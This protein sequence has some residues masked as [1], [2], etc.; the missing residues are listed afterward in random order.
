M[1]SQGGAPGTGDEVSLVKQALA[2]LRGLQGELDELRWR[3]NE[4]VAI[5]GVGCR[6]PG[7]ND[8]EELWQLLLS[9]KDAISEVPKDRWDI[10]SLY[11]RDASRPG[12]VPSRRGGFLP[13]L[14]GMDAA[15]FG[16]SPREAPHVDP[17]QRVMLEIAWEALEDAGIPPDSLARSRTGVFVA[18]LTNDYDHLLFNDLRRAEIYSG[19]GTANSVVA[20]RL[21]YF[22]NL[23]G[24]SVALDTACSGS[25]VAVHL[26]CASLRNGESSLALAG[27]VSVN[28][29]A[30]SNVFFARSGALSPAGLCRTFDAAADG[31]VRSDG[32]AVVVLKRLS[33]ALRDGNAIQA[34]VRGSAVNHD[35]HSNGIMAPNGEAQRAVLQEAY[36]RAGVSPSA[37]QFIELHGTGTPLG[38]PIE[39]QA[40]IDVLGAGRCTPCVVG[41]LKSNVGHSEAAAGAGG[42]VKTVLAMRHG[43]IP[44][45]AN[46]HTLNPLIPFAGTAFHV[47]QKVEPW[48]ACSSGEAAKVPYLAGVSGFGF[49]GTNAHVVLEQAPVPAASAVVSDRPAFLLPVSAATPSA[50]A[51][52]ATRTAGHLLSS[53]D[54]TDAICRSAALGRTHFSSRFAA[55]G[56]T[57]EDLAAALG[58]VSEVTPGG[59][60]KLAFVFSGQGSHWPGMGKQL[61][62]H[63]PVFRAVLDRCEL[64]I[65]QQCGWSL[66]D[67]MQ[68]LRDNDTEIVQPSIFAI[69]AALGELWRSWGV[70][71]DYVVGHSLGEAAAAHCAG[72]LSLEDALRVVLLRS[73]LMK[74]TAG[75]GKTAVVGLALHDADL[76]LREKCMEVFAKDLAVAG[77]NSP[78]ASVFSGTSQAIDG[79]LRE[80]GKREIFCREVAGVD[81][82]FH[83]PQME[84]LRIE[85]ID[86]LTGLRPA[87]AAIPMISTVTGR[88]HT[89][90]SFDAAYWG[91]NLRDPFLFT[92]A[93]EE[94]LNRGCDSFVEVSPHPVLSS[95]LLQTVRARGA[96]TVEVRPSLQKGQRNELLGLYE[97][98][99]SFYMQGRQV[100]WKA[101]YPQ[102]GPIVSLPHYPWQRQRFWF[103]QLD[104]VD[105]A[106]DGFSKTQSAPRALPGVHPL[107]GNRVDAAQSSSGLQTTL[108]QNWILDRAPRYLAEHRVQGKAMMPGAAWLEMAR[109]VGEQ[110]FG[111]PVEV[112]AVSF[113]APLHL[114]GQPRELQTVLTRQAEQGRLEIFSRSG[115]GAWVRHVHSTVNRLPKI[116]TEGAAEEAE[117]L[118][119]VR[120]RCSRAVTEESHYAAM[121]EKGLEYGPA[122]RLLTGIAGGLAEAMATIRLPEGL[123]LAGYGFH[124]A[125]LDAALQLA[126]VAQEESTHS[127]LPVG[128]HRY[129]A[130][131]S[132]TQPVECLVT[133]RGH[134]GDAR[135][136]AD[137]VLRD[138]SGNVAAR[139]DGLAL[140]RLEPRRAEA[141]DWKNALIGEVWVKQ[142]RPAGQPFNPGKWLLLAAESA[143][144]P[145]GKLENQ[146][147]DQLAR[148]GQSTTVVRRGTAFRRVSETSVEI[149]ADVSSDFARLLR[150]DASLKGVVL[151]PNAGGV[152][153]SADDLAGCQL[154]LVV[155]QE[156]VKSESRAVL[157]LVTRCG[158]A[159]NGGPVDPW[160]APVA[161]FALSVSLEHPE[162]QPCLI[163]LAPENSELEA[164]QLAEELLSAADEVRV[165]F[166]AG[167]RFVSRLE[168]VAFEPSAQPDLQADATYLITGGLGNLGMQTAVRMVRQGARNL[169]LTS[170]KAADSPATEALRALGAN[171]VVTACDLAQVDEVDRLFDHTLAALPPLRG[172]VHAAGVVEDTLLPRQT[173]EG[174][175]RVMA[176][177]VHGA[178]NLHQRTQDKPLD[179]F[180][181]YSSAASLIGSGGQANY[182]AANSFLDAL[183]HHR[184][185]CGLTAVSL[186]WGAWS[187]PGMAARP[188]VQERLKAQGVGTIPVEGALNLLSAVLAG[189]TIPAQLGVFPAQWNKFVAQ[190]PARLRTRLSRI[191]TPESLQ[192]G[193]DILQQLAVASPAESLGLLRD[194]LRRMLAA[195]LGYKNPAELNIQSRFFD[196]GMDSLTAVEFRNRLQEQLRIPLPTTLAFDYPDICSLAEFLATLAAPQSAVSQVG[197]GDAP[198]E[199]DERASLDGLT[200]DEISRL[201]FD[202]LAEEESHGR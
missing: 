161:G 71:P 74:R 122:F 127:Y 66:L 148:R 153:T 88:I 179:F 62:A 123:D 112:S 45:T 40:L 169:V 106:D 22:F 17:R 110:V 154:A 107:L 120:Q 60:G 187:G 97:T 91:R 118:D 1:N 108:W 47:A 39:A 72:I 13:G 41:S 84:P 134:S 55:V 139:L 73:R 202:E 46:F 50:L 16:I 69:Q 175:G 79:L 158:Q 95:S 156:L 121:A 170:R 164:G 166:R 115:Q 189:H 36:R 157:R 163:D 114:G 142:P 10:D 43:Q 198:T 117:E 165:A 178:W 85:L 14:D 90:E 124:P 193:S 37:V 31:I 2:A 54:S 186:N 143:S 159:I 24:P 162:L 87:A 181:L 75:R 35:G 42:I 192:L 183:A 188:E 126:A 48:P 191:A 64:L 86:L 131:V 51:E 68:E 129:V 89:G 145:A 6:F 141:M 26:A 15:F 56:A 5:I 201:L 80:M 113:E 33:E 30:K 76:A 176:A 168:P 59:Q 103:D 93:T 20:N 70:N 196:L 119:R 92:Q 19:A 3:Q 199:A 99:A 194:H 12:K 167:Q 149:S 182:A 98:L 111:G 151:L 38:D 23:E 61:Y 94:L 147:A 18:T 180:V 9:G 200:S 144:Q 140:Q 130:Y 190:L 137:L 101:V 172:V 65:R 52:L 78:T 185:G 81:I 63:E 34:V 105:A 28:L 177:K 77:S 146:L 135:L 7:G 100:N 184:R 11:D 104:N 160:Q 25:L 44:P 49:G 138:A 29:M 125:M 174:F 8:P 102:G 4:P 82:A 197:A 132:I 116:S 109:E 67:A 195:V 136:E 173:A 152:M 133:L 171:V 58:S 57:R 32:A 155:A 128:V 21:S 27:G 83:S 150:E 53:T 96:S